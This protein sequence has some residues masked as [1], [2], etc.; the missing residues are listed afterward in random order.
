MAYTQTQ[1]DKLEEAL[2]QGVTSVRLN[3]RQVEYRS[4]EEMQR[5]RDNIRAE[6]NISQAA[7]SR[8]RVINVTGGKGL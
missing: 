6:L 7:G 2:A 4:L 3:G 5:L 1:L 8:S